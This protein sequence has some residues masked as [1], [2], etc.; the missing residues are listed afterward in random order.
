MSG[1]STSQSDVIIGLIHP[2]AFCLT[3]DTSELRMHL[4]TMLVR[5]HLYTALIRMD[6]YAPLDGC[7]GLQRQ[8]RR[9]R[10]WGQM[11]SSQRDDQIHPFVSAHTTDATAQLNWLTVKVEDGEMRVNS[12]IH[13]HCGKCLICL[14]QLMKTSMSSIFENTYIL[15]IFYIA[16]DSNGVMDTF[17]P[18]LSCIFFSLLFPYCV[19]SQVAYSRTLARSFLLKSH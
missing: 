2:D 3:S 18:W 17:S 8:M 15:L 7:I 1:K 5:M 4:Y 19:S 9:S 12:P 6:L 11:F 13:Q 10:R 14:I 16:N